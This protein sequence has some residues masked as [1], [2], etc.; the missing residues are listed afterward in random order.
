M[1]K[2]FKSEK[3]ELVF[4]WEGKCV[5]KWVVVRKSLTHVENSGGIGQFF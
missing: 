2:T 4:H 3:R 5:N 1:V